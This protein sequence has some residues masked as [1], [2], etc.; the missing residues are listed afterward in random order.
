MVDRWYYSRD[1][2][3]LGPFSGGQLK[4]LAAEGQ[5]LT[6]DTVWQEGVDK[7]SLAAKVRYL[8]ATMPALLPAAVLVEEPA[9]IQQPA[10]APAILCEEKPIPAKDPEKP[11]PPGHVRKG[12]AIGGTGIIIV[13]QDGTTV[14]FRKKCMTC[15][16]EDSSWN[17]MKI[18]NGSTRVNF[19]CPKCRK[20]RSGEIRGSMS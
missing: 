5:I 13:G 7:G 8:F 12:R 3:K 18:M 16:H 9:A 19:F 6:T 4:E 20:N 10:A 11:K 14:K 1:E 2:S 17:T 15:G